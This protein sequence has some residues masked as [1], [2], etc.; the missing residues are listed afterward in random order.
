MIPYLKFAKNTC[1]THEAFFLTFC[2]SNRMCKNTSYFLFVSLLLS[3][4]DKNTCYLHD[5]SLFVMQ[6]VT[7]HVTGLALTAVNKVPVLSSY[8][9]FFSKN[10]Y[11][12][13]L[14]L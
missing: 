7:G 6:D 1:S 10:S 5:I 9:F 14:S 2:G 13:S 3:D 12:Y 4:S 11:Y 8:Q